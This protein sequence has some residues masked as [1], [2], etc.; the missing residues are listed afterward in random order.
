[1]LKNWLTKFFPD[2]TVIPDPRALTDRLYWQKFH[3]KINYA[4][5]ADFNEKIH[6]LKLYSDTSLWAELTDKYKV[7]EYVQSKGLGQTL[8]ELYA[9]WATADDIDIA[10]LPDSFIMKVNG[11]SGDKL[12]IRDKTKITN[13]KVQKHF[14]KHQNFGVATCEPHYLR[15]QPC[16][17]AEKLLSNDQP[18]LSTSLIDYKFFCFDGEPLYTKVIYNK[19]KSGITVATYNSDWTFRPEAVR[20]SRYYRAGD[21]R[22]LP[23]PQSYQQLLDYSRRLAAGFPFVRVDWY[24][25]GGQPIFGEMTF[26][27]SAGFNDHFSQAFLVELGSQIKLPPQA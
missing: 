11:G 3:Q 21:G 22:A 10:P 15:I 14:R 1:M 17:I 5:P 26:T 12:V 19:N 23:R 4:A 18:G 9:V 7:R 2:R 8:N 13:K 6:W 24:E 20:P 25:I 27:P 16:I